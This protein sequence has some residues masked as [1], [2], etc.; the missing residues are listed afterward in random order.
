MERTGSRR[1]FLASSAAALASPALARQ[2]GLQVLADFPGGSA[3]VEQ[4]DPA[5]RLIRLQPAGQP[6][7]GWVCWWYCKLAGLEPGETYTLE[8]SGGS[9]ALPDRA[10]VSLDDAAW[11]HTEPGQRGKSRV[12]YSLKAEAREL[13]VAWG[14]PYL[15]RHA[16]SAVEQAQK[17]CPFAQPFDLCKS[18]DGHR[19]PAVRIAQPGADDA[20]RL[21][22]WI[23]ARQHA[24][25][26]GSSWVCQ[27]LLDWLASADARAETLRKK[28]LLTIVPIMDAD[29][30]ERGA[31]GKNQKPHDHN[32]DWSD[33]AVWPEVD[34]FIDLHNPGAGDRQPFF[35]VPP[36]ELLTAARRRNLDS[37]L[38][39]ARAEMTGPLK[40]AGLTKESGP[41]Y[42]ANWQRISKNWVAKNCKPHVT[43]VCLETA[44]NTPQSTQDNYRRFGRELGLAVERFLRD[45]VRGG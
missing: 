23:N 28:A 9:F 2:N 35:F 37:F 40:F 15:L 38:A 26:S 44:W 10:M 11:R 32:R 16:R 12:S 41:N 39:A 18:R 21:G 19:V 45:P 8:V 30:V 22:V 14:P 7:R 13:W 6:E 3:R 42:D 31:G 20:A 36:Q 29:N 17:A 27:G 43:A 25:E 24:W 1:W 5:A 34:L 33:Q 4:V